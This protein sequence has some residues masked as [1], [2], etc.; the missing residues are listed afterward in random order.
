MLDINTLFV[1]KVAIHL[2]SVDSTNT[3]LQEWLSKNSPIEGTVVWADAQ[4]AGRGQVGSRWE[5]AVKEN[6]TASFLFLPKWLAARERF[7]LSQAV[8]LAIYD[9]LLAEGIA[10]ADLR[11]KWP[12]DIYVGRHKIAG[13]LIENELRGAFLERSIVGIG[14]NVNQV[15]FG[16][17]LYKATSIKK[18]LKKN[19]DIT[20]LLGRL[21]AFLEYRYLQL[22][23]NAVAIRESYIERLYQ[24]Q[25]PALYQIKATSL[26]VSGTIAGIS[27]DGRLML[28]YNNKLDYFDIKELYFL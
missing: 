21:S 1:G 14:I 28:S 18:N 24:Y 6:L 10:E 8:A 17:Q 15:E 19:S 16:Q 26:V 25:I 12:N 20:Q 13:V 2:E 22:K 23:K 5:A 4:T 11:I 3:Y 9:C 27:E 7:C